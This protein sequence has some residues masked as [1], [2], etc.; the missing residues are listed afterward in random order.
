[1][2]DI[3]L[4]DYQK[5]M[6]ARIIDGFKKDSG[7]TVTFRD[8]NRKRSGRILGRAVMVQM[9]TGTGKTVLMAACIKAVVEGEMARRAEGESVRGT[10]GEKVRRS[11]GEGVRERESGDAVKEDD[12]Q[13]DGRQAIWVVAHRREL[14][15]QIR[16]TLTSMGWR[17]STGT[18]MR[19]T[20]TACP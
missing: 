3:T 17:T 19:M 10:D 15:E 5:A 16:E 2:K 9:P 13:A 11:E 4:F 1:M 14:V 18:G 6:L 12:T 20:A 8:E 7:R